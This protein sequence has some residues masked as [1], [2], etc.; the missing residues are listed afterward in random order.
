MGAERASTL[1]AELLQEA[2]AYA[3]GEYISD[4]LRGV[5]DNQAIERIARRVEQLTGIEPS[6]T[7]IFKGRVGRVDPQAFARALE[8]QSL[9]DT[10][11]YK[12]YGS[13]Y[14]VEYSEDYD[15]G[16]LRQM[17][18]AEMN[19]YFKELLKFQTS[20]NYVV[21]ND[22]VHQNWRWNNTRYGVESLSSLEQVL[23]ADGGMR[24]LIAHGTS[25]LTTPYFATKMLAAQMELRENS[26]LDFKLYGGNH[27]FYTREASR[28]AFR[29][30]AKVLF[31]HGRSAQTPPHQ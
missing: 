1:T 25:D 10:S 23:N 20:E 19:G 9:A 18:S 13:K 6:Q 8:K 22:A 15:P 31:E 4:L 3:S 26:R 27:M 24:V 7:K 12:V 30:D 14:A 21:L 16:T 17:L 29:D 2:E 11:S 28:K 5:E